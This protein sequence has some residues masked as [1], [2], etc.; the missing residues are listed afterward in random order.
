MTTPTSDWSWSVEGTDLSLCWADENSQ[1]KI[2]LQ[3]FSVL[4]CIYIIF[5]KTK[6]N[7]TIQQNRKKQKDK[8][9]KKP[10]YC[11]YKIC[12]GLL[13]LIRN[14]LIQTL[15]AFHDVQHFSKPCTCEKWSLKVRVYLGM[16]CF[17]Q[18]QPSSVP[19]AEYSNTIQGT[20]G[21]NLF[22][23]LSIHVHAQG[24]IKIFLKMIS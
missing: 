6:N 17:V 11:N 1:L 15:L 4:I 24:V 22:L 8:T 16:Y 21:G 2:A 12:L 23:W 14:G 13:N 3:L 18:I 9:E 10:I 20:E 5:S 7:N 19:N